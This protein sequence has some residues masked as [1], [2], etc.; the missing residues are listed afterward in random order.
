MAK[1]S[2]S[3]I[4]EPADLVA[5]RRRS[6]LYGIDPSRTE[7]PYVGEPQPSADAI[8]RLSTPILEDLLAQVSGSSLALVMADR[9]GRLIYRDTP[10]RATRAVMSD[11]SLDIGFSL[12]E[13]DTGTNGVGTSLETKRPVVV[14]GSEHHLEWFHGFTCANAPI[15][16]PITGKIEATVGLVCPVED[17]QPLLLSTAMQLSAAISDELLARATP[18][19]RFLLEQFL[20]RRRSAK[21]A[22]ATLGDGVLIATP[23]AQRYLAGV[24]QA[25]L[26][27][28]VRAATMAG[29]VIETEFPT[30]SERPLRLRCH[31]LYRGG[32]LGGAAVEFVTEPGR[33]ATTKR[34]SRPPRLGNLVGGSDQWKTVVSDAVAAAEHSEPVIIIG[35]RGTGRR[36]IAEAI[37][38]QMSS[39]DGV[40]DDVSDGVSDDVPDHVS[41]HAI[42]DSASVLLDGARTW[43]LEA[44]AALSDHRAVVLRR[45]DQLPDDVAAALAALVSSPG[46]GARLVATAE[47]VEADGP[48]LAALMDQLNVVRID[49][50][51]LRTRREDIPL[52]V[53]HILERIGRQ[54]PSRIADAR[55]MAVLNRQPWPGNVTELTQALRSANAKARFGVL[56]VQHLPRHVLVEDHRRP[57]HGLQQQEADAI[58]AAIN[59]TASR[60]EAARQLGI[61]R[62]TLYRRIDAYGLDL[63]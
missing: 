57:L 50:P 12:A 60:T 62:A 59:S 19:E 30:N 1:T 49:V 6:D 2:D 63:D 15:V 24:D 38:R 21:R 33:P 3:R 35:E 61:S 44:R 58:V 34:Q 55:V 32:E 40:S 10:T 18:A 23:A 47:S 7:I 39:V 51:P 17:T 28:H 14:T 8:T 36:S 56:T 53:R 37:I 5:A 29:T 41:D 26:W 25:E 4:H 22:L 9:T 11:R 31:P 16:Q 45:V 13:S 48:G 27:E 42:L 43:L 46:A 52:L 20:R 54:T